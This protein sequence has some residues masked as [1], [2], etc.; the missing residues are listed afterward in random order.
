MMGQSDPKHVGILVLLKDCCESNSSCVH[1][2][3]KITEI[4]FRC[5]EL[6][7]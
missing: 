2:L 1:L 5:T 6:K 3:V 4:E 7:M